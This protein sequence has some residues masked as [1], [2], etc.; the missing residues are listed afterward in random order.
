MPKPYAIVGH[1]SPRPSPRSC[2][3]GERE[4]DA[5]LVAVVAAH[6]FATIDIGE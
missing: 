6:T 1:P 5:L 2:L 3:T 4:T